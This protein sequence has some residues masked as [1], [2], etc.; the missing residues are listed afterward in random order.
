MDQSLVQSAPSTEED[1]WDTEGFVIPSLEIGDS[2]ESRI[3]PI[4]VTDSKPSS[5]ATNLKEENIYLGPHGAPPLRSK[6][7]ELNSSKRKQSLKHK[8]KEAD[9]KYSGIGSENKVDNL[10][11]LLGSGKMPAAAAPKSSS[12]GWLDPHC[13]ESQFERIDYH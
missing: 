3:D 12:K 6:Q 1:E 7:P 11:E 13:L 5:I 9:R 8:L 2:G 4:E 10:R